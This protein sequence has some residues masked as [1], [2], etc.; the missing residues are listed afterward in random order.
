[1][2][3]PMTV[4]FKDRMWVMGGWHGGRLPHASASNSVWSSTDGAAWKL[5]TA[6]AGWSPRMAGGIIAFRDRM[7]ILGGVQKYYYGDDDDL[8]NDVW[9]S[10]DGVKWEQATAHAPWRARA[11]QQVVVHD[12]KL[13]VMGGGNYVTRD[14]SQPASAPPP[15]VADKRFGYQAF[16]DVWSSPDGVHWT[17]ATPAA[18]WRARIWF[19]AATYRDHMWVMGGWSKP[20][21]NWNDVWYS[22]DGKNW[23]ELKTDAVWSR[24]HEQSLYVFQD[25]LWI[26]GGHAA[27]L[28]NSVWQLELPKD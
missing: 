27:P 6:T 13:W 1:S 14:P 16:N 10:A 11:Y 4:T 8:R 12:G 24:R 2:D 28:T 20:S 3:F 26:I 5:E 9:S 18:P 19:S 25:K 22:K 15:K 21:G 7:W 17:E 23:S